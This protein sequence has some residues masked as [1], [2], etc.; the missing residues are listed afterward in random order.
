MVN[1]GALIPMAGPV[2]ARVEQKSINPDGVDLTPQQAVIF[3]HSVIIVA[4]MTDNILMQL[5]KF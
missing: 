1:G 5:P 3:F 4:N 2:S